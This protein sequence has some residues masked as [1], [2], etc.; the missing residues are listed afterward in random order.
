MQNKLNRLPKELNLVKN[1]KKVLKRHH[2]RTVVPLGDDAF[3]FKSFSEKT[4]V[5]QDLLIEDVH[6]KRSYS[7]S[8]DLGHKSLAVNLSDFAAMGAKPHFVH[9][10]LALP[11]DISEDWLLSYYSGMTSLADSYQVEV[12]GGDLSLSPGPIMIDVNVIGEVAHPITRHGAQ[13]GDWLAVT[14][15]LG[16]S[17]AGMLALQKELYI[18]AEATQKHLRPN[19]RLDV[20]AILNKHNLNTETVHAMMDCSDGLVNDLFHLTRE[21]ELGVELTEAEIPISSD[22]RHLAASLKQSPIDWALWGGE[23]YELLLAIPPNKKDELKYIFENAN[24]DLLFIGKFNTTGSL[25]LQK[26]DGSL[27]SIKEFQGWSHFRE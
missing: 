26:I 23:D 7:N 16:T 24:L 21:F 22:A 10:S 20:A 3:V 8:A 14:G 4:V 18:Y 9:V 13:D 25:A 1:L 12:V 27:E 6:F 15:S 11:N 2:P 19:P 17:H 5:A